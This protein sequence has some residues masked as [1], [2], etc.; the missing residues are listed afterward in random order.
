MP[1]TGYLFELAKSFQRS[2]RLLGAGGYRQTPQQVASWIQPV[3]QVERDHADD[4]RPLYCLTMV[5]PNASF[6]GEPA[7]TFSTASIFSQSG[8]V[9][10]VIERIEYDHQSP[11][12]L[13]TGAAIL[14]ATPLASYNPFPPGQAGV[15]PPPAGYLPGFSPT[16]GTGL[17]FGV[18]RGLSG[19]P[20]S[21]V[22]TGGALLRPRWQTLHNDAT[23]Y[24]L[25]ADPILAYLQPVSYGNP[26]PA[27]ASV[28]YSGDPIIVPP[29]QV[30]SFQATDVDTIVNVNVY[31]REQSGY[32]GLESA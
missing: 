6:F 7:T 4:A 25:Y 20:S 18:V 28:D 24:A 10:L 12:G 2:I 22:P 15:R 26:F 8:D 13:A 21:I 19:Y 16:L 11:N 14:M 32:L 3:L 30:V 23:N 5:V 1:R 29:L 17:G 9:A 31:Y 27:Q